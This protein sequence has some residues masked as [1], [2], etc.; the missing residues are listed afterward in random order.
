MKM[1]DKGAKGFV[2]LAETLFWPTV[3]EKVKDDFFD[4]LLRPCCFCRVRTRE[5]PVVSVPLVGI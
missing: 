1:H 3:V 2:R 4:G 5:K